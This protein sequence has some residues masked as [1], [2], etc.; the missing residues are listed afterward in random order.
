L[1]VPSLRGGGA[2]RVAVEM[3]NR[4]AMSGLR[5]D[6]LLVN[7]EGPYDA[8]LCAEVNIVDFGK[9]RA[10]SCVLPLSRYLRKHRPEVL[11]SFL[12][13]VN[14]LAIIAKRLSQQPCAVSGWRPQQTAT[15]PDRP[16]LSDGGRH[17]RRF[18]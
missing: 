17:H 4:L 16:L 15:H 11:L 13:H 2:E 9:G 8:E 7:R 18:Q 6:L 14:I 12:N 3:S 1:F 5:V 10:A